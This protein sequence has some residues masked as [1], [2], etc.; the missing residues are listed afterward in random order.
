M[1]KTIFQI[2]K[3]FTQQIMQVF[4]IML[5]LSD[6]SFKILQTKLEYQGL[7]TLMDFIHKQKKLLMLMV[8]Q[9]LFST[10]LTILYFNIT[11]YSIQQSSIGHLC[12]MESKKV[13]LSQSQRNLKP[14]QRGLSLF[15]IIGLPAMLQHKR[16]TTLNLKH[17]L[18]ILVRGISLNK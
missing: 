13:L 2:K 15:I 5:M 10:S 4:S 6:Y 18:K 16:A 9:A 7:L 12:L 17:C 14:T 8:G 1:Q 3:D 11:L